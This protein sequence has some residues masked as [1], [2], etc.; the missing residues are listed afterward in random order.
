MAPTIDWAR[1]EQELGTV[2]TLE[3]GATMSVSDRNVGRSSFE[4]ILGDEALEDAVEIV[5]H[6]GPGSGAAQSVLALIRSRHATEYC[7]RRLREA[8]DRMERLGYASALRSIA[9]EIALSWL[10]DLWA[11]ADEA[12]QILAAKM[13]EGIIGAGVGDWDL[14]QDAIERGLRHPNPDVRQYVGYAQGAFS[15]EFGED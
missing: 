10:D 11:D 13:L 5:A 14:M 8:T 4:L 2:K 6:F 7:Y 9:H 3:G 1:I 12:L 15:A